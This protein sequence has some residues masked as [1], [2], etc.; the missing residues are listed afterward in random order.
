MHGACIMAKRTM[1]P[2][3]GSQKGTYFSVSFQFYRMIPEG[4]PT[5]F[6]LSG[7]IV[8]MPRVQLLR[9]GKELV[10]CSAAIKTG[11]QAFS[12]IMNVLEL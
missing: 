6:L 11:N 12:A 1:Y 7:F 2:S 5:S 8:I 9:K 10:R 4:N 3:A